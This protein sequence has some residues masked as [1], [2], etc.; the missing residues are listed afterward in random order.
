MAYYNSTH[1]ATI[2]ALWAFQFLVMVITSHDDCPDYFPAS[3]DIPHFTLS[4]SH[5]HTSGYQ[6]VAMVV[7]MAIAISGG[8]TVGFLMSLPFPGGPS[9]VPNEMFD[10]GVW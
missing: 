5:L 3:P 8:L 10:D 2:N 6:V 7:T 4:F 1:Q 9:L